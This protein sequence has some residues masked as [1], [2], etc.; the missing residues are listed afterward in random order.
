MLFDVD[1]E[2]R[3]HGKLYKMT[4]NDTLEDFQNLILPAFQWVY[5]TGL[6]KVRGKRKKYKSHKD[7]VSLLRSGTAD[8]FREGMRRHL[9]NHFAR[10]LAQNHNSVQARTG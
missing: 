2:L 6:L 1:H 4:G 10:I 7:L 3:F 5:S 9:E 8:E